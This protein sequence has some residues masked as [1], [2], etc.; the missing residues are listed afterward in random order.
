MFWRTNAKVVL[1]S[2]NAS[3][4][5]LARVGD[6]LI[7]ICENEHSTLAHILGRHLWQNWLI[8]VHMND[9]YL[10]KLPKILSKKE[11]DKT[12]Y[13]TFMLIFSQEK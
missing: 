13:P 6:T 10:Y 9:P 8:G 7:R 4:T 2:I 1:I 11:K 12:N 3:P 5:V